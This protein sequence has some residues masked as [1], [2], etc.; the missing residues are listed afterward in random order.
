MSHVLSLAD[1]T[2]GFSMSMLI[3][4]ES[5]GFVML[6]VTAEG[7]F[8]SAAL[9]SRLT[10]PVEA[11]V[12]VNTVDITAEGRIVHAVA[13]YPSINTS[14]N[15]LYDGIIY[16]ELL[17][18]LPST[19]HTQNIHNACQHTLSAVLDYR[20]TT[21]IL[22]FRNASSESVFIPI[23]NNTAVENTESFRAQLSSS[24]DFVQFGLQSTDVLIRD[25][26]STQ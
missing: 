12:L 25:D 3:I 23:I 18:P 1:I 15:K 9:Q 24:D 4:N 20:N 16:T 8:P 17:L 19:H 10:V 11:T 14:N 26:D 13:F 2:I 6:N 22:T 21:Q 7:G 5:V